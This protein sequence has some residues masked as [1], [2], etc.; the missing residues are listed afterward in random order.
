MGRFCEGP[1]P[2]TQK[3]MS[4]DMGFSK[5]KLLQT[6]LLV[7]AADTSAGI[8]HLLLTGVEGVTLRAH[9]NTDVLLGGT[10]L[11]HVAAGAPD[12]GLLIIRVEAFLHC[13][14]TSFSMEGILVNATDIIAQLP[15][16]CK[17]IF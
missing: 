1:F 10:S 3:P 17:W 5:D 16:K 8:H 11:D 9:F 14:F 12:G 6:E 7:E 15:Q 13:M 4:E 2:K